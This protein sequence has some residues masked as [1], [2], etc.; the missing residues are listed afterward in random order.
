VASFAGAGGCV[1]L[2]LHVLTRGLE[3]LWRWRGDG[4]AHSMDCCLQRLH[5]SVDK[6][7]RQQDR[8]HVR[9][10]AAVSE[11]GCG[12]EYG[13]VDGGAGVSHGVQLVRA[14][15]ADRLAAVQGRLLS[16]GRDSDKPRS[17]DQQQQGDGDGADDEA[18]ASSLL[19]YTGGRRI[20][21]GT[22]SAGTTSGASPPGGRPQARSGAEVTTSAPLPQRDWLAA[23]QAGTEGGALPARAAARASERG[24]GE[25]RLAAAALRSRTAGGAV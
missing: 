7:R 15:R 22:G 23:R 12:S 14:G 11:D 5:S 4:G 1:T 9:L 6:L 8:E 25:G 17:R 20:A 16:S 2:R 24:Q 19:A 10:K 21:A 3:R 13:S 18:A